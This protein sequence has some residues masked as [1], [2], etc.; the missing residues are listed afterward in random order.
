MNLVELIAHE[1]SHAVLFNIDIWRGHDFPHEEITKY[2]KNY[3]NNIVFYTKT[4]INKIKMYG[5][6]T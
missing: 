2:L 6:N 5:V 4:K 1:I 3:G